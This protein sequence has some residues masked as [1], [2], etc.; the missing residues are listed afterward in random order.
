MNSMALRLTCSREAPALDM[1]V[2]HEETDDEEEQVFR[3][4]DHRRAA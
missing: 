3:G 4:T 2:R 1:R